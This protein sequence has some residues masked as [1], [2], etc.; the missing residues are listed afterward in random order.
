MVFQLLSYTCNPMVLLALSVTPAVFL[1]DRTRSWNSEEMLVILIFPAHIFSCRQKET[2]S[3]ECQNIS[4][5]TYFLRPFEPVVW[6]H[7]NQHGL[8]AQMSRRKKDRLLTNIVSGIVLILV[9]VLFSIFI[10][11]S[12]TGSEFPR[13]RILEHCRLCKFSVSPYVQNKVCS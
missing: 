13:S 6:L 9:L 11:L 7:L 10:F 1:A 2:P 3:H 4:S 8:E 5:S 12:M